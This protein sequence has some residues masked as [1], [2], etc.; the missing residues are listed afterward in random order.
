MRA[1]LRFLSRSHVITAI[2]S[3]FWDQGW[4][5]SKL[6]NNWPRSLVIGDNDVKKDVAKLIRILH[7]VHKSASLF[8]K[9]YE[10]DLIFVIW[11]SL[12]KSCVIKLLQI[13]LKEWNMFQNIFGQW[14]IEISVGIAISELLIEPWSGRA[15]QEILEEDGNPLDAADEPLVMLPL[16]PEV[17]LRLLT[18]MEKSSRRI[19]RIIRL[20]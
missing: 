5:Q 9:D 19:W 16:N 1:A 13:P 17:P 10:N 4:R 20:L 3:V 6:K 14:S 8:L 2:R 15:L 12:F 18:N 11:W 7:K